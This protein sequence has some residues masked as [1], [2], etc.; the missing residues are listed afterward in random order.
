MSG[1]HW[2][3]PYIGQP[4]RAHD[5]D[6]WCFFRRVQKEIFARDVPA[7]DPADYATA[8]KARLLDSHPHR[9]AWVEIPLHEL[10]EGDGV[11][12]SSASDPGHVGV[13]IDVDGGR[14]LHCDT[15][16]G[17]QASALDALSIAYSRIR[18]YRYIG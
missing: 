1:R 15:P 18:F 6:C 11:I 4:W 8:T 10:R 16:L 17:V 14:V 9:R 13:W 12:M 7:V 5:H 3:V 2:A